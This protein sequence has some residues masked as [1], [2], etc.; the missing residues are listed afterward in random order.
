MIKAVENQQLSLFYILL[1]IGSQDS[2]KSNTPQRICA[3]IIPELA[4][5][6]TGRPS[7]AKAT[8][9]GVLSVANFLLKSNVSAGGFNFI[10][11]GFEPPLN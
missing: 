2:H 10:Q 3:L 11:S 6:R 1:K 8:G 9:C 5:R 4:R 7:Q